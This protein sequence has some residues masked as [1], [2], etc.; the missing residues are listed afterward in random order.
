MYSPDNN[1]TITGG[2]SEDREKLKIELISIFESMISG[3][4]ISE[5]WKH[6]QTIEKALEQEL[7]R[8]IEVYEKSIKP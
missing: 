7:T 8:S 4:N 1:T 2:D 5:L 3:N 6:A